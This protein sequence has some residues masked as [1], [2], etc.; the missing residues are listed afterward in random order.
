[1]TLGPRRVFTTDNPLADPDTPIHTLASQFQDYMFLPD[2]MPLYILM[3]T[4]AANMMVG[5]AVWLMLVG[6]SSSGKT[7]L[8]R[9]I[10]DI[11]RVRTVSSINGTAALLSGTKQKERAKDAT[12][13]LLREIGDAGCLAFM[14]FT[15]ILSKPLQEQAELL[16]VF[17]E[18]YDG[19]WSRQ[20]GGEGGR[21]LEYE[22]KV[23]VLAAVTHK[24]DECHQVNSEMGERCLYYRMQTSP[25][26]FQ[27]AMFEPA[28]ADPEK[29]LADI[30][31]SVTNFFEGLDL[32]FDKLMPARSSGDLTERLRIVSIAQLGAQG[33][34]GVNRDKYTK[35]VIG[36]PTPE[37][38]NRMARQLKQLY[39]GM[40]YIGVPEG[41]R[42][43]ALHR[44]VL[45]SI[46][47]GRCL[48]LRAV[49]DGVGGATEIK[50]KVKLSYSMTKRHL[51]D[52]QL[53]G[54]IRGGKGESWQVTDWLE[55]RMEKAEMDLL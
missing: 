48:V 11:A 28:E 3:G 9:T 38:P 4:M 34:S 36:S 53:L 22:G 32:R 23:A 31:L 51:E 21:R 26:G 16:S 7:Y 37:A 33:R 12:G 8:L 25:D 49:I 10:T 42:W 50:D 18:L 24:I 52:L 55:E 47:R 27:E 41:E 29:S 30:K 39:L 5:N 19:K 13:G 45:D 6:T 20:I 54:L 35:E 1:M 46:P 44:I 40:E 14:D 17:R 43:R 2:P 15:A